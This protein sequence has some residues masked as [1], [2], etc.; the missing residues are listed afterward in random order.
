M[1]TERDCVVFCRVSTKEQ[2]K[3]G[4]GLD[5]QEQACRALAAERGLRVR[6]VWREVGSG[7]RKYRPDLKALEAFARQ[8]RCT[9]ITKDLSR[10]SR[11]MSEA[12]RVTEDH[13]VLLADSPN[14]TSI[15]VRM[16]ALLSSQERDEVARRTRAALAVLKSRGVKLGSARPGA[17]KGMEHVRQRSL[18]LAQAC[19]AEAAADRRH[20]CYEM[21]RALKQ[22]NP[23]A[24]LSELA[25]MATANDI[26]PP[27]GG[28]SWHPTQISRALAATS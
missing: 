1:A 25:R 4:L 24:N 17:W 26:L 18:T 19:A 12:L 7:A 3:S 22:R 14:A 23:D 8:A 5:A 20:E 28:S 21:V 15:E 10:L 2:G 13:D 6:K 11:R 9:I 16:R 27:H